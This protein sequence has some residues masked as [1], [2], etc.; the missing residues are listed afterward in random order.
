MSLML[1]T[2]SASSFSL[3]TLATVLRALQLLVLFCQHSGHTFCYLDC[4]KQ[5]QKIA[6]AFKLKKK[7][8]KKLLK[9]KSREELWCL[10]LRIDKSEQHGASAFSTLGQ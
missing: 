8:A 4:P 7:Y 6:K 2:V 10:V 9:E 3:D 5:I 1:A